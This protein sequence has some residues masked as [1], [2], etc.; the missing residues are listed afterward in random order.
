LGILPADTA[1]LEAAIAK[2]SAAE[3]VAKGTGKGG[4]TAK[5]RKA[6]EARIHAAVA[7][8]A[9]AGALAFATDA[10]MRGQFEALGK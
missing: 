3:A 6:A 4:I 1:A 8:I 5:E 2:V 10:A 7:R 9:G